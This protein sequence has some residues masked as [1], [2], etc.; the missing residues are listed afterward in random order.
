MKR[1]QSSHKSR[2]KVRPQFR[3]KL[4]TGKPEC[5]SFVKKPRKPDLFLRKSSTKEK[6]PVTLSPRLG[7]QSARLTAVA[8]NPRTRR[9]PLKKHSTVRSLPKSISMPYG[10]ILPPQKPFSPFPPPLFG[11]ATRF[12]S[13]KRMTTRK[14]DFLLPFYYWHQALWMPETQRLR[15]RIWIT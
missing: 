3:P 7:W 8:K 4:N 5:F 10:N 12:G 13:M 9:Q 1:I 11:F 6:T 14:G 15:S 2:Q